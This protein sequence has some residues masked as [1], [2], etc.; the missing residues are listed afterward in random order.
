MSVRLCCVSV[1]GLC[2]I[3]C[4]LQHFVWGGGRFFPGHS[5]HALFVLW[6]PRVFTVCVCRTRELCRVVAWTL[7]ETRL[8]RQHFLSATLCRVTILVIYS[9]WCMHIAWTLFQQT[10]HLSVCLLRVNIV[11][12]CSNVMWT[13]PHHCSF[14]TP[15]VIAEK[16]TCVYPKSAFFNQ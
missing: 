6:R 7:S 2:Y 5:A 1:I 13:V 12:K 9:A 14:H 10:V 8:R 15:C 16:F 3:L 11:S 4:I